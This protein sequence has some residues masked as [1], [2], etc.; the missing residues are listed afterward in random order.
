MR[1]GASIATKSRCL[2]RRRLFGIEFGRGSRLTAA[3]HGCGLESCCACGIIGAS[4][5]KK[6]NEMIDQ[7][8]TEKHETMLNRAYNALRTDCVADKYAELLQALEDDLRADSVIWLPGEAQDFRRMAETG[9]MKWC[10]WETPQGVMLAV[11][12]SEEQVQR[13]EAPCSAVIR[14]S[15]VFDAL[16]GSPEIVGIVLNPC[17]ENGGVVI[18]REHL[19]LVV[20]NSKKK[21]MP[22]G[23]D[24]DIISEALFALWGN[25]EGVPVLMMTINDEVE[26]LGGMDRVVG[27]VLQSWVEEVRSGRFQGWSSEQLVRAGGRRMLETALLAGV[28]VKAQPE[29]CREKTPHEWYEAWHEEDETDIED[30]ILYQIGVEDF[31]RGAKLLANMERNLDIYFKIVEA[32]FGLRMKAQSKEVVWDVLASNIGMVFIGIASFGVGWG[33]ALYYEQQG[34]EAMEEARQRQCDSFDCP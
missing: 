11:F 4:K 13:Y 25:A 15:A 22:A 24:F 26:V 33:A 14:V 30:E 12:T 2:I 8:D 27:P 17:D 23:F 7:V 6:G 29:K 32:K 16:V 5:F 31:K 10:T 20:R 21:G 18:G 1:S 34:P 19:E 3:D 9:K 28:M